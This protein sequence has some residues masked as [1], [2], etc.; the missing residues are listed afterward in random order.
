MTKLRTIR[1]YYSSDYLGLLWDRALKVLGGQ[2]DVEK[3]KWQN[4]VIPSENG[5]EEVLRCEI[6][7]CRFLETV[8]LTLSIF[9]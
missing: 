2:S 4:V 8:E 9:K 3:F 6:E 1:Q 7:R 5:K